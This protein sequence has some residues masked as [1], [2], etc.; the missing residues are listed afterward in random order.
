[1]K[2][3]ALKNKIEL[4]SGIQGLSFGIKDMDMTPLV[5]WEQGK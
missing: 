2:F 3:A 4:S 1:M 5:I